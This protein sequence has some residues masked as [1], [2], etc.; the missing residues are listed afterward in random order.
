MPT[1]WR[2]PKGNFKDNDKF[3]N[4]FYEANKEKIQAKI[5]ATGIVGLN[6]DDYKRYFDR[7]IEDAKIS[8]AKNKKAFERKYGDKYDSSRYTTKEHILAKALHSQTLSNVEEESVLGD[9]ESFKKSKVYKQFREAT[10]INGRYIKTNIENAR[11]D[12]TVVIYGKKY[13]KYIVTNA[14]GEWVLLKAQSPTDEANDV[15]FYDMDTWDMVKDE[16][17]DV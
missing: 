14:S 1:R 4:A 17:E 15:Y 6:E 9:I 2:K 5:D 8:S 10:K 16:Y 3:Y 12:G 7:F 11:L 13:T